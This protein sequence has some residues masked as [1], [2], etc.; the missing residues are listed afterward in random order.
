MKAVYFEWIRERIGEA[1]E[2]LA[3]PAEVS[4]VA[5]LIAWL[6]RQGDGYAYA[7]EKAAVVR[8]AIDRRHVRLDAAIGAA[9]EIAFFPP[10]TGG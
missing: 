4:T 1:E 3:P 8:A 7:F 10:L 5:E 9:R 6:T 2:E